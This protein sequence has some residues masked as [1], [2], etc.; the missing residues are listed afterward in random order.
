LVLA[1]I[2][3]VV[4]LYVS[5]APALNLAPSALR[6]LMAALVV[7]ISLRLWRYRVADSSL[8]ALLKYGFADWRHGQWSLGA[9]TSNL[10]DLYCTRLC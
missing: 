7:L 6:A 3:V 8:I 10:I 9:R 5:I 1:I 4:V 2:L